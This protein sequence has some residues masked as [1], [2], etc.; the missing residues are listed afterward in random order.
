MQQ[1]TS[2]LLQ[3]WKSEDKNLTP[4]SIFNL[5][6]NNFSELR[7]LAIPANDTSFVMLFDCCFTLDEILYAKSLENS[8]SPT[9]SP[10]L[11]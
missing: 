4:E 3:A 9:S 8:C 1:K 10:P 2:F 11:Q 6:P 7:A 5:S